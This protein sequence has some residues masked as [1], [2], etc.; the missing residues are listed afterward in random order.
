[1]SDESKN[2][3]SAESGDGTKNESRIKLDRTESG[4]GRT[5][6]EACNLVSPQSNER[7]GLLVPATLELRPKM[8]DV[9]CIKS[10][11]TDE[12]YCSKHVVQT[13][14]GRKAFKEMETAY[15]QAPELCFAE[16]R[17][18]GLF[19]NWYAELTHITEVVE[20]VK[21]AGTADGG[22]DDVRE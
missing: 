10:S 22:L 5:R 1:M 19:A 4:N 17:P 9:Y 21:E 2:S 16:F 11:V 3:D 8:T 15:E 12:L 7:N 14:K 20:K 6:E 18:I 13:T